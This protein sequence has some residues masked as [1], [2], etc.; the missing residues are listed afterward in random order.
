MQETSQ[1]ELSSGLVI[2]IILEQ[3]RFA[4]CPGAFQR[5]TCGLFLLTFGGRS[6]YRSNIEQRFPSALNKHPPPRFRGCGL[7][8]FG[9]SLH[10]LS[11]EPSTAEIPTRQAQGPLFQ[12]PPTKPRRAS[13]GIERRELEEARFAATSRRLARRRRRVWHS[14]GS[15]VG[16]IPHF[17]REKRAPE[18]VAVVVSKLCHPCW[19]QKL[20]W[21]LQ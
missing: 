16:T 11:N 2:W 19:V 10:P 6:A 7:S 9:Q 3:P 12:A 5:S 1:D 18:V 21:V 4:G 8:E 13:Q 17:E 14:D 20:N 15:D